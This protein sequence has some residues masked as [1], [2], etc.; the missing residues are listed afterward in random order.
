MH[1]STIAG[2]ILH[3]RTTGCVRTRQLPYEIAGD[4]SD[5]GGHRYRIVT[6]LGAQ[7]EAR[8]NGVETATNKDQSSSCDVSVTFLL[9]MMTY[10]VFYKMFW[11]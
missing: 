4:C 5:E 1:T 6:V 10:V 11:S 8:R 7:E 2:T 3:I 9:R